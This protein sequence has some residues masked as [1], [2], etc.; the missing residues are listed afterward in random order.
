MTYPDGHQ[1]EMA[2]WAHHRVAR[3]RQ[4]AEDAQRH[5]LSEGASA[6]S[7]VAETGTQVP[8]DLDA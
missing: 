5:A 4:Q 1:R 6:C 3:A 7:G 2:K 8:V